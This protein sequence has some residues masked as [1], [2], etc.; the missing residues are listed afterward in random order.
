MRLSIILSFLFTLGL[1]GSGTSRFIGHLTPCGYSPTG[2][3]C[4]RELIY[5]PTPTTIAYGVLGVHV[6]RAD[7]TGFF[8]TSWSGELSLGPWQTGPDIGGPAWE[9]NIGV[10]PGVYLLEL[11]V[12]YSPREVCLSGGDWHTLDTITVTP[13]QFWLPLITK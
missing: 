7:G 4:V 10:P 8:Q 5:N 2:A 12:C 3:T 6:L 13:S 1:S 11:S 9:D